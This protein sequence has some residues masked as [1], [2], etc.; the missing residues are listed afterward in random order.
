MVVN[1]RFDVRSRLIN[2]AVDKPLPIQ[3]AISGVNRVAIEI[4]FHNVVHGNELWRYSP[5]HQEPVRVTIVPHA[6][7][8]HCIEDALIRENA[9]GGHKILYQFWVSR[10]R[11]SWGLVRG[12]CLRANEQCPCHYGDASCYQCSMPFIPVEQPVFCHLVTPTNWLTFKS[13]APA[14]G[15]PDAIGTTFM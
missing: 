14:G 15:Y 3:T 6:D 7:V 12:V 1:D 9:V 4:E 13:V 8:P 11:R 5:R 2:F 10:S